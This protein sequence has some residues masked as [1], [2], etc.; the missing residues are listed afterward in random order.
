MPERKF[1]RLCRLFPR[2]EESTVSVAQSRALLPRAPNSERHQDATDRATSDAYGN[3]RYGFPLQRRTVGRKEILLMIRY[4]LDLRR[5]DLVLLVLVAVG[6]WPAAAEAAI[7]A[8]RNETE[9][10][11]MVQ[12]ISIINRVARRGKLHVLGPGE[13]GQEPILVPGT[14]LIIVIDPKQP[15]RILCQETIQFTG[16]NLYY[17][18]Q[19]EEVVEAKDGH[20]HAASKAIERKTVT[21][22]VKLVPSKPTPPTP[23]S[24]SKPHR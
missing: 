11:I 15:T 16:T 6:F 19:R 13:V 2:E 8:F 9:S 20:G 23:L 10:P 12:G 1:I 3:R 14:K 24:P 17:A 22:K 7:L 18:I 4:L 5:I 21:P